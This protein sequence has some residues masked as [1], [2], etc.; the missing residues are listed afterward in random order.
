MAVS[1]SDRKWIMEE[2]GTQ[3]EKVEF[4]LDSAADVSLLPDPSRIS[5]SSI[6]IIKPTKETIF[7][8]DGAWAYETL[9]GSHA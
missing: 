2:D 7:I 3:K 5:A 4:M 9:G 6:A 1:I 8:I